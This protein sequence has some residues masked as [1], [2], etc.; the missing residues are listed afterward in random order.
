MQ[1]EIAH[2]TAAEEKF[3]KAFRSC[4]NP[5]AIATADEGRFIEV[6]DSFLQIGGYPREEIIGRTVNQL[7]SIDPVLMLYHLNG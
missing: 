4:P 3:A 6:N 1:R 7:Y 5:I 2:K